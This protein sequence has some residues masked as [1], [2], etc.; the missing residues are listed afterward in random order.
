MNPAGERRQRTRSWK[1]GEKNIL[2]EPIYLMVSTVPRS[3]VV[4]DD[5]SRFNLTHW[6]NIE[7]SISYSRGLFQRLIGQSGVS[8]IFLISTNSLLSPH[9]NWLTD[10]FALNFKTPPH[11]SLYY[12]NI[13]DTLQCEFLSTSVLMLMTYWWVACLLVTTNGLLRKAFDSVTRWSWIWTKIKKSPKSTVVKFLG[14]YNGIICP[15]PR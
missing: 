14:H 2:Q 3:P 13:I 9:R 6:I 15:P 7:N 12:H 10:L 11:L 8:G 1:L 5:Y 4:L